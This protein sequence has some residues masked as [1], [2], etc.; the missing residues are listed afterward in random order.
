MWYCDICDK[1]INNKSKSK[2]NNSSSH[3]HKQ[4][5][6]V[7]VKKYEFIRPD[8][9]RIDYIFNNCARCCYKN[10]FHRFKFIFIY[11]IEMTNGDFVNGKNSDEKFKKM[12]EQMVLYII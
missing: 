4:K 9:S 12:F 3:K 5:L 1:T 11:D 10:I 6:N 7:V 2:H 8:K